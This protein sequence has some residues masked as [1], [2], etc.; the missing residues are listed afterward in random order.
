MYNVDYYEANQKGFMLIQKADVS[1]LQETKT[2]LEDKA[3]KVSKM[4]YG[5]N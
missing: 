3:K 5:R 2:M 4:D 1:N